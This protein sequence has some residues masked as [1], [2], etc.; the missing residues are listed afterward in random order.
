MESLQEEL[1]RFER[2]LPTELKLNSERLALMV[3]SDE[4]AKYVALWVHWMQCHCDLYRF[5]VPGIREAISKE[6][7]AQTSP[8]FIAHCQRQCLR[9]AIRLCDF[10]AEIWDLEPCERVSDRFIPVSIY[11]V[12]QILRQLRHLLPQEGEHCIGRL[13]QKLQ[14]ALAFSEPLRKIFIA[15]EKC[16]IQAERVI[17]SLGEH[18]TD[19]ST[20]ASSVDNEVTQ[21]HLASRFSLVQDLLSNSRTRAEESESQDESALTQLSTHMPSEPAYIV[22]PG[23]IDIPS[24]EQA[25]IQSMDNVV[26]WDPFDVQMN[27][28]YPV[29]G[30]FLS[31]LDSHPVY[32]TNI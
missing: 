6:V 26:P 3:H 31:P 32:P 12:A 11:Q 9:M 30:D 13:Q 18:S 5:C 15:S 8:D 22:P 2:N 20:R 14:Y 1:D 17:V 10:W 4:S 29:L 27:D 19:H 25:A 16:L 28:Y 23:I 21:G 24:A 7:L